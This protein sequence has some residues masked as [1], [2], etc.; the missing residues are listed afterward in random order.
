MSSRPCFT[1]GSI[2]GIQ[3]LR[4]LQ[5]RELPARRLGLATSWGAG[6]QQALT[7]SALDSET[8]PNSDNRTKIVPIS[9]GHSALCPSNQLAL[10]LSVLP[11]GNMNLVITLPWP[12]ASWCHMAP[13]L[14]LALW[15]IQRALERPLWSHPDGDARRSVP[16]PEPL[17]IRKSSRGLLGR[18]PL[19]CLGPCRQR[20][21]YLLICPQSLLRTSGEACWLQR[22]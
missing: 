19:W 12:L 3:S 13:C 18:L 1:A 7:H 10:H 21:L 14:G 4:G 22:S 20:R 11:I 5:P 17:R 16:P 15:D 6:H 2:R 8:V 9:I